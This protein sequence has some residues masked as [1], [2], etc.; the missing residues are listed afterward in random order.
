MS[1]Q[2]TVLPDATETAPKARETDILAEARKAFDREKAKLR[3]QEKPTPTEETAETPAAAPVLAAKPAPKTRT[4]KIREALK[5]D[6]FSEVALGKLDDDEVAELWEREELRNEAQRNT[7]RELES[8]RTPKAPE[9]H[10]APANDAEIE[11][12]VAP[13]KDLFEDDVAAAV[14][15]AFKAALDKRDKR[16]EG[17]ETRL[18][19]ASER[20]QREIIEDNRERLAERLPLLAENDRAWGHIEGAVLSAFQKN[21]SAYE[22]AEDAFDAVF[23]DLYGDL[24]HEPEKK[25]EKTEDADLKAQI[26][27]A[28]PSLPG[29]SQQE[30]RLSA[31]DKARKVLTSLQKGADVASAQKAAGIR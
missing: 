23:E 9:A 25:E 19:K 22:T 5:R 28:A 26:A 18:S 14:G 2:E 11:E 16:I 30:R 13:L 8:L 3:P 17:L 24:A 4:S 29:K 6:G 27:A 20:A 10:A 21:A 1:E 7:H 15:K 31:M 12:L